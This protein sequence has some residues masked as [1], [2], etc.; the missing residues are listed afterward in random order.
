MIDLFVALFGGLF[1]G[2]KYIKE[3]S[4]IKEVRQSN[5]ANQEIDN[6]YEK[7]WLEK[8]TDKELEMKL[9]AFIFDV[10]NY[11]AV[12]KEISEAYREMPW[13][14]RDCIC[15]TTDAVKNR[16]KGRFTLKQCDNI[17]A[18]NRVE[19]LRIMLAKRG[20]LPRLDAQLG[21]QASTWSSLPEL[22]ERQYSEEETKFMLWITEQLAKHGVEER[23]FF[24]FDGKLDAFLA[25]THPYYRGIYVWEPMIPYYYTKHL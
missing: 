6:Q 9:E 8:V 22:T 4:E 19:A 7:E 14:T 11:D 20:K 10:S 15:L 12:W 1:W 21:I 5:E 2:D 3:K 16:Y 13:E 25:S 23:L 17:A 18:H 24:K